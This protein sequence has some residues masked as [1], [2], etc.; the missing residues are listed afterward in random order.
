MLFAI[1]QHVAALTKRAQ[2]ARPIVAGI[3]VEMRR[4]QKDFGGAQIRVVIP[5]DGFGEPR[6]RSPP[7]IAPYLGVFIP[8]AAVAE[9]HH[10]STM[11][12]A[13]L[14]AASLRSAEPNGD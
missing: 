10:R 7:A 13:A 3:V 6:Q 14:L 12:A 2:I 5:Y 9:M 11:R 4:G 1:V 8:P